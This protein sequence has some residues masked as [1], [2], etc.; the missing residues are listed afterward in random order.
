M[1]TESTTCR[2]QGCGYLKLIQVRLQV[3]LS[4]SLGV[5]DTFDKHFLQKGGSSEACAAQQ[6]QASTVVTH[7]WHVGVLE[8]LVLRIK[9][10]AQVAVVGCNIHQLEALWDNM[11]DR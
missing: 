4:L 9:P 1:T 6:H 10:V 3:L 5:V 11:A 2:R 8:L 7:H